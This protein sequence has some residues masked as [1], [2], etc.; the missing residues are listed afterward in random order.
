MP[1]VFAAPTVTGD[2]IAADAK[3]YIGLGYVY[4]GDASAPG[5]WDCSSFVS[6]VLGHDL[7]LALP[8]NGRWGEPGYPPNSHGPVVTD[9]ASW[10]GARTVSTDPNQARAGDL[11]CFVGSG[12]SGHIG[13]ATGAN[14]MV[15]ALDTTDGTIQSPIAGY[16]PYGAPLIIRR[17]L[18]IPAGGGIPGPGGGGGGGGA[19]T[20]LILMLMGATV[21]ALVAAA[22]VAGLV[23]AAGTG[24]A[25]KRV[26]SQ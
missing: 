14:R 10:T 20:L 19:S 1:R 7:H 18:G 15:S 6:Y 25:I 13:I 21:A 3:K 24:Y 4:G 11:C 17:L 5:V 26:S 8:N 12:A 16:G 9:Y 23:T 2:E 22:A